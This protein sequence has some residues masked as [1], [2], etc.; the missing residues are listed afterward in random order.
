MR[1]FISILCLVSGMLLAGC[2]TGDEAEGYPRRVVPFTLPFERGV[3]AGVTGVETYSVEVAMNAPKTVRAPNHVVV[4]RVR[5]GG[6]DLV[7]FEGG[8]RL[9][10]DG[11]EEVSVRAGEEV[12]AGVEIGE[13][14]QVRLM[15]YRD[16]EELSDLSLVRAVSD[17]MI[18]DLSRV[19]M[20]ED[21]EST[22]GT[23]PE[24]ARS[25]DVNGAPCPFANSADKSAV[26]E[27]E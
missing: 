8:V 9:I 22:L 27:E 5:P 12:C 6:V 16:G 21:V 23:D 20:W 17:H 10:L 3:V 2:E 14:R 4:E 19:E 18:T 24:W 7:H 11:L 15:A 25:T 13:T 1:T 26:E